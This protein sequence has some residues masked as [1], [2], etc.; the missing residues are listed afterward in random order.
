MADAVSAYLHLTE[1]QARAQWRSIRQRTPLAR[2]VPFLPVET[3]LTYGLFYVLNPHRF[4]GANIDQVPPEVNA[5]AATFKRSPGSLTNKMLNLD[6][7]RAN[8]ARHEP[9]LFIQLQEPGRFEPLYRHLLKAARMEGLDEAQVPDFLGALHGDLPIE[10]QGQQEL[11]SAQVA[12]ALDE[13]FEHQRQLGQAFGFTET[14]TSR[15]VEQRVRLA[16]H[17]FALGVLANYGWAC[18][19]CGFAPGHLRG[20]GL[21]IASH[22]KPWAKS[23]DKERSTIANGICACPT[24]DSAFDAG[25]V[26]V[27]TT[28]EIRKASILETHMKDNESLGRAFGP[29]GMRKDLLIRAAAERPHS[30][31]LE[32]HQA[33]VFRG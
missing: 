27:T 33:N 18:G 7:S 30:A 11:G 20:Y 29:M 15:L 14:E 26:T 12:N 28:L 23:N 13:M 17:R 5:L 32:F 4:G 1:A 25:L 19:F 31:F 10:L 8:A 24:H 21:L 2:Q 22:V 6:G 9:E 3:L 16:Q